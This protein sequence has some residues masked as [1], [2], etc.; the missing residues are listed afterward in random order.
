MN[1][2]HPTVGTYSIVAFDPARV[3]ALCIS[4][5]DPG[6]GRK[7]ADCFHCH[8]GALFSHVFLQGFQ[9][10]R[11][12]FAHK[13]ACHLQFNHAARGKDLARLI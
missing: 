9:P 6:R 13:G 4:E 2:E 12:D 3:Q 5:Y 11:G 1:P 7:G 8:G 10:S